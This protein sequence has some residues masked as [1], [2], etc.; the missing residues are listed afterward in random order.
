MKIVNRY[1]LWECVPP[2]I[3][4]S[5][6][7]TLIFILDKLRQ[8]VELAVEKNIPLNITMELFV[9]MLP[10]TTAITI[11]MGV[12]FGTLMAFGRLSGH[13]E[14]IAMRAGGI[15]IY[16]IFRPIFYFGVISSILMF[17]FINY[18]M[19]ETNYRYKVLWRSVMVSNPGI[20]LR[21]RVF[22]DIPNS[23]KKIS[24][25]EITDNNTTLDSVF[26]YEFDNN[27]DLAEI[28]FAEE[29]EWVSNELNSPLITLLLKKGRTIELDINNFEEFK[30][31]EFEAI[32]LNIINDIKN[33]INATKGPREQ[34][35]FEIRQS[36]INKIKN[37]Q[38]VQAYDYVEFHKKF[39]IPAACI[40]FVI[41]GMPLGITFK[42]S[43][44]SMSFGGAI[45]II[46]IYY[47]FLHI[48]EVMGNKKM[49]HPALSM[50]LPNLIL[51][52]IGALIFVIRSRE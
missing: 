13:S 8:L 9:Y 11:P 34:S 18:I 52:V 33:P 39:S 44:K 16:A 10:F 45:I 2:F 51:F 24:T 29:G 7:F 20:I 14:I 37:N 43:G 41:I 27:K 31:L 47:I 19:P 21:D 3:T 38:I 22:S 50:W 12:L 1:I 49:I 15:S 30:N 5:L 25:M 36:I 40:I 28:T 32:T 42:R 6:F 46:F 23:S 26:I 35:A 17:F 48:G 4:G